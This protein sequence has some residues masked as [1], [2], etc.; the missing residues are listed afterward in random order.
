MSLRAI[1][2]D[3][4]AMRERVLMGETL[5]AYDMAKFLEIT[6]IEIETEDK[7]I[8]DVEADLRD[9]VRLAMGYQETYL[10]QLEHAERHI[11]WLE[12][13]FSDEIVECDKYERAC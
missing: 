1:V 2:K 12:D 3:L 9:E 7:E 8:A 4:D 6:A 11:E 5:D 13:E 10:E